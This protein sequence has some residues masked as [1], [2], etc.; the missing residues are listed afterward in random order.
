MFRIQSGRQDLNLRPLDPQSSALA[1]LRHAPVR[2]PRRREAVGLRA[3]F[4]GTSIPQFR[5]AFNVVVLRAVLPY[6]RRSIAEIL[7][8]R[9]GSYRRRG[10][11]RFGHFRQLDRGARRHAAFLSDA[12]LR[13][14]DELVEMAGNAIAELA[15]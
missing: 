11:A 4:G 10:F 12:A 13:S 14:D 2:V 5:P 1:R 9:Q 6:H 15:P 3:A 8:A 7:L